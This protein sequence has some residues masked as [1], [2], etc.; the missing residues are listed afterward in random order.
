MTI[1]A[2]PIKGYVTTYSAV[3]GLS[4]ANLEVSLGFAS[5]T[6]AHGYRAYQLSSPVGPNDFE[7]KDRTKYSGGC[8]YDISIGEYVQ[9]AD[10]LRANLGKRHGYIEAVVDD[11]LAAFRASQ[12]KKLTVRSGPE[13]IVKIVPNVEG[14]TFPDS[15]LGNIPQWRLIVDKVF[16][17]VGTSI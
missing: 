11:N 9:R 5:G 2:P 3:A 14:T 12:G 8:R 17:F 10:E 6:L 13:R 16:T 1:P 4:H 15:P 7:W